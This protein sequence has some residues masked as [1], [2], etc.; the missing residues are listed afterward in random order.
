MLLRSLL[1][2]GFQ[3]VAAQALV[4]SPPVTIAGIGTTQS[5]A[6]PLSGAT[7]L[8][9]TA[10]GQTA[11]VLPASGPGSNPGD[12]IYVYNTTATTA[13][14]YPAGAE[15]IDGS[16]NDVTVAQNAKT[17]FRRLTTTNWGN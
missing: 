13:L 6:A 1:G 12:E 8:L 7:C 15:T 3:G 14:I 11:F 2:S 10:S 4:G 5:G 17:S 16:T 9:T